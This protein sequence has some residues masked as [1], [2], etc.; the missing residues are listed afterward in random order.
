[1]LQKI[2]LPVIVFIIV[3][4]GLTFGEGVFAA[5]ASW[6]HQVTGIVIYNFQDLYL[7]V[8]LYVSRHPVK[9]LAAIV[10]T[11]FVCVW[12][13]KNK[14]EEMNKQAN[15]RKIAIFLAIFLGWLG[16]HRFYAGQIGMGLFYLIISFIWLPL[17][18]FLGLIDAVR[19]IFMSDDEFKANIQA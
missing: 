14:G 9:I 1:M 6:I 18:V 16:A 5:L 19:Y 12:I 4:I 17:T 13:Y 3:L 8:S 7:T 10:I 15:A 2:M 11:A